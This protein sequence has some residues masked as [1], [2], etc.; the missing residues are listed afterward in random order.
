A[1]K[2]AAIVSGVAQALATIEALSPS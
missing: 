2:A 1:L